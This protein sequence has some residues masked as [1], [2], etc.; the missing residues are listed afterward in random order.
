MTIYKP[1][2]ARER[3]ETV[4]SNF[5]ASFPQ[6]LKGSKSKNPILRKRRLIDNFP[7][8]HE[9][10]EKRTSPNHPNIHP[11]NKKYSNRPRTIATYD[12]ETLKNTH[13]TKTIQS[14][15]KSVH[16]LHERFNHPSTCSKC[17]SFVLGLTLGE[18]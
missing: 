18:P 12:L 16:R 6:V 11:N 15:R 17:V 4:G 10:T 5:R 8:F 7:R 2:L 1:V 3:S 14:K 9:N 13:T